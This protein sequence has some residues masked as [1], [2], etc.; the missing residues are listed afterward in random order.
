M[1]SVCIL[2]AVLDV[3]LRTLRAVQNQAHSR[4]S[5]MAS[6]DHPVH[7]LWVCLFA[8]L[9]SS[10]SKLTWQASWRTPLA[11]LRL[12]YLLQARQPLVCPTHVARPWHH[13]HAVRNDLL[14]YL[15]NLRTQNISIQEARV[16]RQHRQHSLVHNLTIRKDE[17]KPTKKLN[18]RPLPRNQR[19]LRRPPLLHRSA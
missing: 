8:S 19:R 14:P 10:R 1:G 16:L 11:R 3:G 6:A 18:R 7:H 17:L 12:H 15:R 2:A 5:P 13:R 9:T 4:C